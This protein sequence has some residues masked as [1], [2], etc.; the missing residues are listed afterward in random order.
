MRSCSLHISMERKL[1][2]VRLFFYTFKAS[3]PFLCL[4]V[5]NSGVSKK[6]FLT[7]WNVKKEAFFKDKFSFFSHVNKRSRKSRKG[8]GHDPGGL[9]LAPVVTQETRWNNVK[10]ESASQ[11]WGF[12]HLTSAIHH[13]QSDIVRSISQMQHKPAQEANAGS[14]QVWD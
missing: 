6:H 9:P 7:I 3:K 11:A 14:T 8:S 10:A 5:C 2:G 1:H 13:W 12:S 4:C